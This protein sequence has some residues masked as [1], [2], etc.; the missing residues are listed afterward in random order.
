M[1]VPTD[2]YANVDAA[3][4]AAVG[5]LAFRVDGHCCQREARESSRAQLVRS[6]PVRPPPGRFGAW[7]RRPVPGSKTPGLPTTAWAT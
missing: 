5:E 3:P 4:P 7:R 2:R 6:D 1:P